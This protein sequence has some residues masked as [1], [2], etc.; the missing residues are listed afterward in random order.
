MLALLPFEAESL[1]H[2]AH[3]AHGAQEEFPFKKDL[4]LLLLPFVC[5]VFFVFQSFP[6]S[7][8]PSP[9]NANDVH[10]VAANRVASGKVFA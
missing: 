9:E 3:G 7:L 5:L 8:Q 10:A 4:C 2:G 1:K 6:F